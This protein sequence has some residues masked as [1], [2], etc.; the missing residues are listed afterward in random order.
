MVQQP[1]FVPFYLMHT[2]G[3][4]KKVMDMVR[5]QRKPLQ[6]PRPIYDDIRSISTKSQERTSEIH[7]DMLELPELSELPDLPVPKSSPFMSLDIS[8]DASELPPMTTDGS[9]LSDHKHSTN[10]SMNQDM[11]TSSPGSMFNYTARDK[12]EE[13]IQI[14]SQVYHRNIIL[15]MEAY[16]VFGDL[17]SELSTSNTIETM[18]STEQT[19]HSTQKL[20]SSSTP[21]SSID[22]THDKLVLVSELCEEGEVMRVENI[23]QPNAMLHFHFDKLVQDRSIDSSDQQKADE[24]KS[25]LHCFETM[26]SFNPTIPFLCEDKTTFPLLS[27]FVPTSDSLGRD[28]GMKEKDLMFSLPSHLQTP[29]STTTT[30][31]I[32]FSLATFFLFDLLSGFFLFSFFFPS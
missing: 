19:A 21:T 29:Q 32:P 7:D 31:M 27:L 8:M 9:H 15:L 3:G 1:L 6:Q 10:V 25:N 23:M 20:F 2:T 28:H 26:S 24:D 11:M 5:L 16:D 22:A 14:L 30:T 17:D 12:V 4:K 13:E 18:D